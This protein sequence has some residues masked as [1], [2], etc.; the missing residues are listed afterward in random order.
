MLSLYY[1]LTSTHKT[2]VVLTL[3][4]AICAQRPCKGIGLN[5][6]SG[7][8]LSVAKRVSKYHNEASGSV[9]YILHQV[10]FLSVP[11]HLFII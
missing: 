9:S 3:A 1:T 2:I 4:P 8:L 5:V 11:K 6:R 7:Y 10:N